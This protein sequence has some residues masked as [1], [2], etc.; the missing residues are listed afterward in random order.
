MRSLMSSRARSIT[1][2]TWWL[3]AG[4]LAFSMVA[5]ICVGAQGLTLSEVWSAIADSRDSVTSAIVVDIRIPRVLCAA[6]VGASLA[7]AGVVLQATYANALV[8]AGLV[9]ISSSAG[10]AAALASV[11]ISADSRLLLALSAAVAAAL[12]AISLSRIRLSGLA[13]VLLGVAVGSA[14][15]AVLG[16]LASMPATAMGRSVASWVFGSFAMADWRSL[17][18]LA[19]G[20]LGGTALLMRQG[21]GLDAATLGTRQAQSL[22]VDIRRQRTRWSVAAALLV[23]PAVAGF[24]VIGFVGL[25]VPHIARLMGARTAS[26]QIVAS[27]LIGSLLT[28]VADTAVRVAF[29]GIEVP[30]GFLLAFIGAPV[31]IRN[32]MGR[33]HAL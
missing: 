20:L 16:V 19:L 17:T 10:I 8:D 4:L 15:T 18:P 23:A 26:R 28:V 9:G 32:L 6:V 12:L 21:W 33:A 22:G 3:L 11:F 1:A 31:L 14:A 24:G 30:V 13:F 5:G 27:A 29:H 7:I 25:V 2:R